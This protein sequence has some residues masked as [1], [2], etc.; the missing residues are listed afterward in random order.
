VGGTNSGVKE[1]EMAVA[2]SQISK[3]DMNLQEGRAVNA[4]AELL[5]KRLHVPNIYL[6][7]PRS[8]VAADV[9]AVDRGGAGDLHAVE[10]KLEPD[11]ELKSAKKPTDAREF[12]Q[13]Q[14]TW[15]LSLRKKMKQIHGQL[16]LMPAHYRYLAIPGESKDLLLGELAPLGLF[17]PDGIGRLG[18]IGITDRG[19]E[20]P[21]AELLIAPERFR[22]SPTKLGMIEAKLLNKVRPDIE[23]RI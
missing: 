18:L 16:M 23:V 4:V 7:P 10:I 13:R 2:G 15:L 6:E 5:R 3:P 12:N 14:D 9:L 19:D 11:F 22:M 1:N 8:I 21:V 17:S 20:A